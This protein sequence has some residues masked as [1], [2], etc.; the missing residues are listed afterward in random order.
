[1]FQMELAFMDTVLQYILIALVFFVGVDLG[2]NKETLKDGT[3]LGT[4]VLKL[5]FFTALGSLL[6]GLLAGLITPYMPL[7]SLAV[8]AGFGW[9]S[10]SGVMITASYSAM[11]GTV[12][13]LANIMRELLAFVLIPFFMKKGKTLEAVSLG[14]A[15]TMDTML[16]IISES[17]GKDLVFP[18][19]ING[20][21]LSLSVTFVVPLILGF[22]G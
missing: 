21:I 13:F 11:L 4:V 7:E 2:S 15:T 16:G 19:I 9:Y 8:S 12:A 18:A 20:L 17:G 5:P 22:L 6:G 14:G 3:R 1:M 10:L